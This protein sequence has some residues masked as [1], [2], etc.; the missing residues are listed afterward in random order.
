[1][2]FDF[3]LG[4]VVSKFISSYIAKKDYDGANHFMGV[5]YKVYAIIGLAAVA[6]LAVLFFF[7]QNIYY[8]LT[9]DE[10][11]KLRISYI[12]LGVFMSANFIFMPLDSILIG[13]D[14]FFHLKTISLLSKAIN[15]AAVVIG[16]LINA[17]LYVYLLAICLSNILSAV[18]KIIY[19]NAKHLAGSKPVIFHKS[20]FDWRLLVTMSVWAFIA[21]IASRLMNNI[22]PNLLGIISGT[23][24]VTIFSVAVLI[25][26]YIWEFASAIKGM[27]IPKL[28]FMNEAGATPKEYDTFLTSYGRV[29]FAVSAWIITGFFIFGRAFINNVWKAGNTVSF[30]EAY[31]GACL[32]LIPDLITTVQ[33]PFESL[34]IVKDK[35]KYIAYVYLASFV[36]SLGLSVGLCFALPG[37][38][39]L[40]VCLGTCI[41]KLLCQGVFENW[42]FHKK[43]GLNVGSFFFNVYLKNLWPFL[44]VVG[45][46]VGIEFVYPTVGWISLFAKAV[47][48]S[49][50]YWSLL[51]LF[52]SNDWE[53]N[54]AASYL[55]KIR[56]KVIKLREPDDPEISLVDV[57]EANTNGTTL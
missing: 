49:V 9:A 28:S 34:A 32:L 7:L 54:L 12:I 55:R 36:L 29:Q 37:Y 20:H 1:V 25:E 26:D 2:I 44:I 17:N 47:I 22:G 15:I 16:L 50:I 41:G 51:M 3:G 19:I 14:D 38:Q 23:L 8:K 18:I 10:L 33:G 13:N 46:G 30:D 43:L 56:F 35:I 52:A 53:K 48:Y 11:S 24:A 31:W 5:V 57:K 21:S 39:V 27:F 4:L 42:V 40:M 45:L 6:I